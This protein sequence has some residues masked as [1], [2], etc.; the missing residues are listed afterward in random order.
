MTL[1]RKDYRDDTEVI[2]FGNFA[3][4]ASYLAVAWL[5]VNIIA[6]LTLFGYDIVTGGLNGLRAFALF[7]LAQGALVG[8]FWLS[9]GARIVVRE[10]KRVNGYK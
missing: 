1:I 9:R 7:G 6:G 5:A 8:L 4:P 10:I 3:V 2:I